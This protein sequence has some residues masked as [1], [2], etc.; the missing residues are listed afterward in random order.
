MIVAVMGMLF[1][2]GERPAGDGMPRKL[3]SD[4][5]TGDVLLFSSGYLGSHVMRLVTTTYATH[6]G[7]VVVVNGL[8]YVWE[9]SPFLDPKNPS[10]TPIDV[11]I[12][13]FQTHNS[14]QVYVRQ[15]IGPVIS[16]SA[17]NDAMTELMQAEFSYEFFTDWARARLGPLFTELPVE[18]NFV[19]KKKRKMNR[20][21][22]CSELCTFTYEHLG[23]LNRP[24]GSKWDTTSL[25]PIHY[26]KND[27]PIV[28]PY[29]FGKL[30]R[31]IPDHQT[32]TQNVR[33]DLTR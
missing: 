11:R 21:F 9:I 2:H 28:K 20:K 7:I 26:A 13:N 17:I 23:V 10:L 29:S 4:L 6:V 8:P 22:Y 31:V 16:S 27:L 25:F 15:L 33:F 19:E 12:L 24:T 30:H 1:L 18:S 32:L 14:G 5:R 3:S